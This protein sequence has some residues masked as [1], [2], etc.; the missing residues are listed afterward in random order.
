MLTTKFENQTGETFEL[1]EGN[2]GVY[3]KL[4]TLPDGGTYNVNFDTNATY[5]E[6]WV[7]SNAKGMLVTI[8]SDE[9]SDNDIIR[10]LPN[11][12]IKKIPRVLHQTRA[13]SMKSPSKRVQWWQ[14]WRHSM[15]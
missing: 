12:E 6:Y 14:F 9:C 10:F 11:N 2:A 4:A 13:D 3:S 15:G 5:R 7:G 1:K 8:S